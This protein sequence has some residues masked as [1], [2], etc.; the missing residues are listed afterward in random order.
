MPTTY[1]PEH[2]V[3]VLL[4]TLAALLMAFI[5]GHR[6]YFNEVSR[7]IQAVRITPPEHFTKQTRVR[8]GAYYTLGPDAREPVASVDE[9]AWLSD[10]WRNPVAY[11]A[12]DHPV[13]TAQH[14]IKAF[15][16]YFFTED[17]RFLDYAVAACERLIELQRTDGAWTYSFEFND[18]R[19]G[20]VSAMAQGQAI[21][22]LLRVYQSTSDSRYLDVAERAYDFMMTPVTSGGTLHQFQDGLPFLEEYPG[23][24]Y[25]PYT[26]NGSIFA[27]WGVRDLALASGRDDID[28]KFEAL[29]SALSGHLDDYDTGDWTRYALAPD[30]GL[31]ASRLYHNLHVTQARVM[32]AITDDVKWLVV[33]NRWEMHRLDIAGKSKLHLWWMD[34]VRRLLTIGVQRGWLRSATVPVIR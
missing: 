9:N 31:L 21:S 7:F 34:T 11:G 26:L 6:S 30:D 24:T 29:S 10:G 13:A 1:S 20:W 22:L 18:L 8:L 4:L 17:T 3:I 16:R 33:A 15:N 27:L 14:G 32:A 19:A 23:S 5:Y 28:A 25:S 2:L 12:D